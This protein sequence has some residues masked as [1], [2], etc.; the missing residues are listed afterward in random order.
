[1]VRDF[2]TIPTTL[3]E[4]KTKRKNIYGSVRIGKRGRIGQST[5]V[6]WEEW[7]QIANGYLKIEEKEEGE[8]NFFFT[9]QQTRKIEGKKIVNVDYNIEEN[10]VTINVENRQKAMM[11][12]LPE[13]TMEFKKLGKEVTILQGV[14]YL[15]TGTEIYIPRPTTEEKL[16]Q[17]SRLTN[18]T[19]AAILGFLISG[20]GHGYAKRWDKAAIMFGVTMFIYFFGRYIS[21]ALVPIF[22]WFP[23]HMISA[24]LAYQCAKEEN[25]KIIMFELEK[26][27]EREVEEENEKKKEIKDDFEWNLKCFKE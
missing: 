25:E 9:G 10:S 6:T 5:P 8:Y 18:P 11:F 17:K 15:L 3:Y 14:Y 23:L 7:T 22:T 24:V 4:T 27:M 2:I 20:L 19:V 21:L 12:L 1:M 16:Q 26:E 13:G